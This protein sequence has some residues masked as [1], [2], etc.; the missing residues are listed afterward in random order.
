MLCGFVP[1]RRGNHSDKCSSLSA[2]NG[3]VGRSYVFSVHTTGMVEDIMTVETI[4]VEYVYETLRLKYEEI[5]AQIPESLLRYLE[6][7][8]KQ[9]CF[10]VSYF[11]PLSRFKS[12]PVSLL[13]NTNM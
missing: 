11:Q 9:V 3:A 5:G 7:C 2:T 6:S 13:K 12:L 1:K 8:M 4:T 10:L